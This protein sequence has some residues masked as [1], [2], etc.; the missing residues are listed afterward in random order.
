[1]AALRLR[2]G[3]VKLYSINSMPGIATK[4][5][6]AL[7]MSFRTLRILLLFFLLGA[8][9]LFGYLYFNG[10]PES[11]KKSVLQ[12]LAKRGI[13]IELADIRLDPFRGVIAQGVRYQPRPNEL[14][15][16]G[17]VALDLDLFDLIRKRFAF[18][19]VKISGSDI[20]IENGQ[21][22]KPLQIRRTSAAVRFANKG[23]LFLE[24]LEGDLM[25]LHLEVRGRLDLTPAG[26]SSPP[27]APGSRDSGATL[28]KIQ[29]VLEKLETFGKP[30]KVV[31]QIDGAVAR[32][33]TIKASLEIQS[34]P[35]RFEDWRADSM[36][37]R[38]EFK[39]PLVSVH[40]LQI[41]AQEGKAMATGSYDLSSNQATVEWTSHLN[42]DH[43]VDA[44][45]LRRTAFP[46]AHFAVP[47]E[48]WF[49][50]AFNLKDPLASLQGEGSFKMQDLTWMQQ[51]IR[52][53][54]GN[55]KVEKGQLD[56]PNLFLKQDFGKLD[57][58][59][60]YTIEKKTLEFDLES[61]LDLAEVMKL[62]YPG[63]RNWF[64][65]VKYIKPPTNR[66]KG[67][68]VTNDPNGLNASGSLEWDEWM[69]RGILV[70]SSKSDIVIRGRKFIFTN[71]ALVREEGGALGDFILDFQENSV[72]VNVFSTAHFKDVARLIGPKLEELLKYYIFP[73]P[74]RIELRGVLYFDENEKN[75]L[76]AHIEAP[77]FR[78]WEFN[79]S[80]VRAEVWSHRKSLEIARLT[81][82]FYGGT[83]EGNAV[84]DLSR[85]EQDWS[86]NCRVDKANFEHLTHDLWEY[87]QVQGKLTGWARISGTMNSA[88]ECRGV[89]EAEIR[90]GLLWTIPL[91]GELSKF[92]PILGSHDAT[93]GMAKFTISDE[94]VHVDDLKISAGL[95][96]LTA[97]GDYGFDRKLDFIVQGHFLRA[98]FGLGYVLDP[99]TKAFEYHLGGTLVDR[100]WKP[101]FIPKELLLQFGD[102]SKK[103]ENEAE[104][105]QTTP[106]TQEEKAHP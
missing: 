66:L 57:G 2:H 8:I 89:G 1:V 11:W 93:K 91:F 81:G 9:G 51:L 40:T 70:Q 101:R 7:K 35:L 98:F 62:L 102:G 78:I 28:G 5:W 74:P 94:E 49:K 86:F 67:T 87:E 106:A 50:G 55:F 77:E 76:Y 96:S 23:I 64:H 52:E 83:L 43:L 17:E 32:P 15:T 99:F 18:D 38:L 39:H 68:W 4:I 26:K 82:D 45:S 90:D 105:I 25:N 41:A 36:L 24:P 31:L 73:K 19:S 13:E 69:S 16:V 65:T 10:L 42:P 27:P 12:E 44:S 3:P 71:F 37:V 47:P 54:R 56:L 58:D 53:T 6:S 21:L 104:Q 59:F 100:V 61:T 92:I 97:K 88:K 33:E 79:G 48:I 14:V 85:P 75:N 63:E 22:T 29:E 84:F 60:K 72:T 34:G 20:Q 95:M 103:K 80:N 46:R 30:I